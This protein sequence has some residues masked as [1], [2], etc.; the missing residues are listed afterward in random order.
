[1]TKLNLTEL[2]TLLDQAIT[3]ESVKKYRDNLHAPIYQVNAQVFDW[4]IAKVYINGVEFTEWSKP[5]RTFQTD[6]FTRSGRIAG[7][8]GFQAERF[9]TKKQ[10][11]PSVVEYLC[12]LISNLDDWCDDPRATEEAIKEFDDIM[13]SLNT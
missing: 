13:K 2:Q 4:G 6:Y 11:K 12:E 8:F 3:I 10:A 5:F 1:M 7:E 9:N